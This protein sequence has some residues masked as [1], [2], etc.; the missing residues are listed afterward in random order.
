[1]ALDVASVLRLLSGPHV[2]ISSAVD[3]LKSIRER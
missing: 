3:N 2:E 1:M